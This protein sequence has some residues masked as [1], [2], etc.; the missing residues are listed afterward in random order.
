MK[1][2]SDAHQMKYKNTHTPFRFENGAICHECNPSKSPQ[3]PAPGTGDSDNPLYRPAEV[4]N[5]RLI[6]QNMATGTR[7]W[8]QLALTLRVTLTSWQVTPLAPLTY[9]PE[10]FIPTDL[11]QARKGY[12]GL[13]WLC[14]FSIDIA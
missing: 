14:L 4:E 11:F 3:Y 13:F 10:S 9:R 12:W 2:F 5:Q 6:I 7:V 8:G 1:S